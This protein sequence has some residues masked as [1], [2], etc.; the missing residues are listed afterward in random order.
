M[1]EKLFPDVTSDEKDFSRWIDVVET[2][3]KEQ[4]EHHKQEA[5]Q[6]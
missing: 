5:E 2:A 1:V 3:V 6:V 4:L